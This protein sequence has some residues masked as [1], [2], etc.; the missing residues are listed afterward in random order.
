MSLVYIFYFSFL[1]IGAVV[2]NKQYSR[3]FLFLAMA[4]LALIIGC[5]SVDVGVDTVGYVNDFMFYQHIDYPRVLEIMKTAKEPLFIL[6]SYFVSMFTSSSIWFTL[7][8]GTLPCIALYIVLKDELRTARGI[9]VSILIIFALGLF[10]FFIAGMRQTAAISVT[11]L[12]YKCLTTKGVKYKL[13]FLISPQLILFAVLMVIAYNLHNSSILFL[14]ILP[15]L[16]FKIRWWYLPIVVALFF[17][18]NYVTVDFLVELSALL[19]EE[20]FGS[21]GTVYESSQSI[22]A[23]VIQLLLFCICFFQRE[24]LMAE[25]ERNGYLFNILVIGLV[26]QA[27]SGM[28]AEM[29]RVSFYYSIFACVLVPKAIELYPKNFRDLLYG[30]FVSLILFYLFFL[31]GS[32]LPTYHSAII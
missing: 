9:L 7:F 3:A 13:S 8:W 22:S 25:D 30:A 31:S 21:Y 6:G 16:K 27:L 18:A 23:F 2:L 17:I 26:F 29:F 11:L 14:L 24:K 12:A 19:F 32:N 15:F 4:F 28:I 5:R 20:R 10:S 1:V